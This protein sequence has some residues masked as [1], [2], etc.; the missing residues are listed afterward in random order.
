MS[1]LE[2]DAIMIS[3]TGKKIVLKLQ[4]E[5]DF[6]IAETVQLQLSTTNSEKYDFMICKNISSQIEWITI[7]HINVSLYVGNL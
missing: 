3:S 1:W 2:Y 5:K 4:M 6:W 7:S